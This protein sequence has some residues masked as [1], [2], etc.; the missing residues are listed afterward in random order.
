MVRTILPCRD[1]PSTG[2]PVAAVAI[3]L[4]CC[5][6]LT[7]ARYSLLPVRPRPHRLASPLAPASTA[8]RHPHRRRHPVVLARRFAA[9]PRLTKRKSLPTRG[10]PAHGRPA[11][12]A[13]AARCCGCTQT[14]R[15]ASRL[16]LSLCWCCRSSLSFPLW[17]YTV[18]FVFSSCH[19]ASLANCHQSLPRSHGDSPASSSRMRTGESNV[20][21]RKSENGRKQHIVYTRV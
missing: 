16:I 7:F 9:A 15:L 14:S 10:P 11:P 6:L 12:A 20:R 4:L 2:R 17:R 5:A 18:C 8:P 3:P 1:H 21:G 13:A 19:R